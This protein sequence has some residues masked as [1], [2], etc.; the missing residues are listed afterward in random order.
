MQPWLSPA[1]ALS[2]ILSLTTTA[3]S[4]APRAPSHLQGLPKK[5]LPAASL[6][7]GA[8]HRISVRSAIRYSECARI[9][10]LFAAYEYAQARCN[11]PQETRLSGTL[12]AR[13][14]KSPAPTH[15]R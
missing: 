3:E 6:F 8:L 10:P 12:P 15:S 7:A 11:Q 4:R 13:R 5:H 2:T 9:R 14:H 1:Q